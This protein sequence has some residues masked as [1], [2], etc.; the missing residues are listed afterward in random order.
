M[1]PGGWPRSCW[2][3]AV[4]C[5]ASGAK[6][7]V[8]T[9]DPVLG[10]AGDYSTNP[11]L[12]YVSHT[13][14]THGA[15][16]IDAPTTYHGD[17]LSLSVLPSFRFSDSQGYSSLASNYA[18][19]TAKGEFDSERG[20][21]T[22]TGQLA[23][24]SSLY[25]NY[26]FNGGTGVR[27]DTS[28]I[29]AAWTRALTERLNF[30]LDLSTTRVLY[31]ESSSFTTLTDYR[32]SSLS[33]SLSYNTSERTVLTLLG[34]VGLYDTTDRTT[35][36]VNSSLEIGVKH[37]FSELWSCNI[38][39]G[40]SRET[41]SVDL[42]FGPYL[43]ANLSATSTGTLYNASV[44]RKGTLL[45]LTASASRSL[46]PSGFSFLSLQEYYQVDFRYQHSPRLTFDGYARRLQSRQPQAFGAAVN[47]QYLDF[48]LSASWLFTE[49]WTASVRASR[50]T[51][52]YTPTIDVDADGLSMQL[53]RRFDSIKWH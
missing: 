38:K 1:T 7:G 49:K 31:G 6:A 10:L 36:S 45:T 12:L 33:P 32:Y 39:A 11:G 51:A 23:R 9:S 22:V 27:R 21:L 37:D 26:Q 41:D 13:A 35:K 16:L 28:G 53:S 48:S 46:V 40:Y 29:D 30:G 5:T 15:V 24:D 4:M 3:A 50:V 17:A 47:Q 14:E 8:W 44:T 25:Y 19:L 34:G 18:H 42:Y 52:R 2:L 20:S 43:L